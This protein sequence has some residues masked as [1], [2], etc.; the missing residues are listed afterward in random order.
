M[1][2]AAWIRDTDFIL[3]KLLGKAMHTDPELYTAP[4]ESHLQD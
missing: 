1:Q 3:K 4:K 2:T